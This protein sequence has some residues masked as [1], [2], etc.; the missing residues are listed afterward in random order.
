MIIRYGRV[1]GIKVISICRGDE[2][3]KDLKENEK[4]EYVLDS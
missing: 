2:N 3:V 4:A 1:L